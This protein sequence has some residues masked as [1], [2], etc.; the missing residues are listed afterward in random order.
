[1]FMKRT[2]HRHPGRVLSLLLIVLLLLS[3]LPMASLTAS[4]A[5]IKGAYFLDGTPPFAYL[6]TGIRPGDAENTVKLYQN[7]DMQ[8][9]SGYN[10]VYE[11]PAQVYNLDDMRTYTVTEISGARGTAPGALQ[12]VPLRGVSLPGTVTDIGAQAFGGCSYLTEIVFPTSVVFLAADAFMGTPLRNL[13]LDVV[14]DTTLL[15]STEYTANN[16][17]VP[18]SLPQRVSALNVRSPLSVSGQVEIPDGV[19]VAGSRIVVQSGASL[20]LRSGLSG[21][22]MVQVADNGTLTLQ[23]SLDAYRGTFQLSGAASKLVNAS[24]MPVTVTDASGKSVVVKA[25]ETRT[26]GQ[27]DEEPPIDPN[28]MLPQVTFNYGGTVTVLDSGKVVM[29]VPYEDYHVEDVVIN[30]LSMGKLTRYEFA[31]ASWQ[32]RVAVTFAPGKAPVGPDKPV[33]DPTFRFSDVPADAPY[34]DSV[35]FLVQHGIFQGIENA[36]F[37]PDRKTT[38]SMFISLL[39]RLETYDKDFRVK[40]KE[41]LVAVDVPVDSWYADSA[42]W[43]AGTGLVELQGEEFRADEAI[44]RKE[45]I[46][47]LYRYTHLRGYDTYISQSNLYAHREILNLPMEERKAMAWALRRGYLT[48]RG[49][50]LDLSGTVTRAETAQILANY[51]AAY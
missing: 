42:A 34:A 40:C 33:I 51:V 27:K 5:S 12:N 4:A 21:T 43:A 19:T 28:D 37:A 44:S 26:G 6:I 8:S 13:T 47:C 36:K 18:I 24:S 9:Y 10:G 11:I 39:K 46:M 49:G 3:V 15:S 38:R 25:G 22:G 20:T 50:T 2:D 41:P 7:E 30:G 48:A 45:L 17:A 32:N 1:M 14:T 16:R 29:I 23:G 31:E 35:N